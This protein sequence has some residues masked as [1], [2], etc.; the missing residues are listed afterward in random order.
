MSEA[1]TAPE[2]T[3]LLGLERAGMESFVQ[4]L[5]SQPFRARQLWS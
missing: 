1:A 4:T 2:R 3:N 5:G